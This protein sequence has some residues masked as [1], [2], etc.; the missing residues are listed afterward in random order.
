MKKILTGLFLTAALL[1]SGCTQDS[2]AKTRIYGSVEVDEIDVSSRL[3][4]RVH[5]LNVKVGQK[6]KAGDLL[7]EFEDDVIAAKRKQ[8]L[9]LMAAAESRKRRTAREAAGSQ[10]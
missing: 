5:K 6:V 1:P 8:A 2:K 3:P 7:V 9:A 4:A 10:G